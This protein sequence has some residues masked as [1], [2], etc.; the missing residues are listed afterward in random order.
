MV[1]TKDAQR[2]SAHSRVGQ[3]L[4]GKWRLDRLI[5]VGGMGAVYAATHRNGKQVAVKMLHAAFA[6]EPEIRS[7]FLREGYVA[8]H[9][10]HPGSVSVLD[11]DTAEDGSAF[12]V[13]ELLEGESLE[14]LIHRSGNVMPVPD[15]LLV[16]DQVLDVLVAA[17]AKGIVHRDIKPANLFLT[18]PGDVK[19]L[20]F[21]FARARELTMDGLSTRTGIVMGT[22]SYMP[23]EQARAR[24]DLVDARSDIFAVGATMFRALAGRHV[25]EAKSMAERMVAAMKMPAPPLL[26]YAPRTPAAVAALVD[27]AL[28]Y[29][30]E[31]RWPDSLSMQ[32]AVRN[33]YRLIEKPT[34]PSAAALRQLASW[35]TGRGHGA[36][37]A[38]GP[39]AEPTPESVPIS[40]V[41]DTSRTDS[42][43]VEFSE[44][45]A[46][47]DELE[48]P[49]AREVPGRRK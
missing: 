28:A 25:H 40:V 18:R 33:A 31:D 12:L 42:I 46:T 2:S 21:G 16:V 15:L 3:V 19:V 49:T 7:R 43:V 32:T 22:A 27:R 48:V 5:D 45:V 47:H 9:V 8:N 20:D 30:K 37:A 4:C 11:D 13:M 35:G 41:V 44:T 26:Q 24:W 34:L 39:R 6:A 17:H 10:G 14:S 36:P 38:P 29:A 1:D 23:P